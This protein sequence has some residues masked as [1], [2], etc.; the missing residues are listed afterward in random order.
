M[1]CG[2]KTAIV[3]C[4]ICYHP[5][6]RSSK[7]SPVFDSQRGDVIVARQSSQTRSAVLE[8]MRQNVSSG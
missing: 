6:I 8:Y 1:R 5:G 4:M 3:S 2:F 7:Q